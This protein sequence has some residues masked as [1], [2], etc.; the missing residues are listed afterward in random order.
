MSRRN[1][2]RKTEVYR[3]INEYIGERGVSPT[4]D[5]IARAMSMAKS[6]VSKYVN[7]LADE[8][9]IE[10]VGRYQMVTEHSAYAPYRMPIIGKIACGKPKLALEDIK[11]YIPL[12]RSLGGGEFFCLIADGDSMIEAG[13]DDG[14]VVYVRRQ[15]TADDGDIVVALIDDGVSEEGEATLKR[16]FRDTERR[17]YILH[18]EN[19][20]MKDIVV[21]EVRILG[22][23]LRVLKNLEK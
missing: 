15:P 8:G 20:A 22:V 9:H 14:D 6:T 16:F 18:P 4:T 19:R 23:A 17:R 7:R 13:I 21:T 2:D 1:E 11:G 12:D 10:R 3:F 5:E